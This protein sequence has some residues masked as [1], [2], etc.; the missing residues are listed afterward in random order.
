[1][2]IDLSNLLP[3]DGTSGTLIGR[4]CLPA[5]HDNPGGPAPVV[6]RESGVFDL[7]SIAATVSFLLEMENPVTSSDIDIND[8]VLAPGYGKMNDAVMEAITLSAHKEGIILDPVYTGRSMAGF[9]SRARQASSEQNLLF[10]HTGGQPAIF[11]YESD[12]EPMLSD[13][14]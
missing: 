8:D 7:S 13:N 1:M 6:I 5:A 12:L 10:L 4:V 3:T 11:G 2:V 14:V 9:L